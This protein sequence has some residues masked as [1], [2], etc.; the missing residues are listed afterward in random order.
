MCAWYLRSGHNVCCIVLHKTVS[1]SNNGNILHAHRPKHIS[2]QQ[3]IDFIMGIKC[4]HIHRLYL[5]LQQPIDFMIGAKLLSCTHITFQQSI[6]ILP[7]L[8][9]TT[10]LSNIF[11]PHVYRFLFLNLIPLNNNNYIKFK[12]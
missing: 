6:Y 1:I 4:I 9:S 8:V 12:I 10:M 2:F 5:S 11:P 3:S 7:T